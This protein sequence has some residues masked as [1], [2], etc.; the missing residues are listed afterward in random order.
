MVGAA[1]GVLD[2]HRIEWD[3]VDLRYRGKTVEVKSSAYLQTW[4]QD[5]PSAIRFDIGKKKS[6]DATTNTSEA[7]A[8]RTADCY[9]FCLYTATSVSSAGI[10]DVRE[11]E[12]YVLATHE[13]DRHFGNQET[14]GLKG[15]QSLC[16]PVRYCELT[17]K[18]DAVLNLSS[19]EP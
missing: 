18:V 3:A 4:P 2:R 12:F 13:I 1:L 19:P 8:T 5:R 17:R 10:L 14:V 9:V 11:W 7:E 6:W 15:I 16:D